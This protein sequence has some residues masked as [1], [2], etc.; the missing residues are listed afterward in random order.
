M[1]IRSQPIAEDSIPPTDDDIYD[2]VL[3][4]D[5]VIL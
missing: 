5:P 4:G 3:V 2:E 1:D